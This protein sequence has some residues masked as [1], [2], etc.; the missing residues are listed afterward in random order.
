MVIGMILASTLTTAN[1]ARAQDVH[2]AAAPVL[3]SPHGTFLD[4]TPSYKWYKV[5]NATKYQ[6]QVYAGSTKILDKY[7]NS[8]ACG[9]TYCTRIPALMLESGPY[10]WMARAYVSGA[11]SAWTKMKFFLSAPAFDSQFN[12]T[13]DGWG[14]M[15][16]GTWSINSDMYLFTQGL[17]GKY[18]SAYNANGYFA[19]FDYN[20]NV[21]RNGPDF[22]YLAVRMGNLKATDDRWYPGYLFGY[23]N[24]GYFRILRYNADGSIT[25]LQIMKPSAA[26]VKNGW[27]MLRVVA[28]DTN[29]KFY[30]NGVLV[31]ELTDSNFLNGLVGL[32]VY[33]SSDAPGWS[34]YVDYA[35]LKPIKTPQ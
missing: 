34:F 8:T 6:Y 11:W 18:S 32:Q 5:T 28:V 14:K 21:F 23:Y 10:T 35:Q 2:G 29:F 12:G 22:T 33:R 15:S 1:F 19:D 20:A 25:S 13:M 24:S 9:V 4:T 7:L 31:K 16:G 26:I 17:P 30:I 27:N 3:K